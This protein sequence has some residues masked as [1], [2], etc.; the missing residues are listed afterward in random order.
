MF[1]PNWVKLELS[2]KDL[3][4][5]KSRGDDVKRVQEWL[6]FNHIHTDVDGVYGRATQMA[7]KVFQKRTN[8]LNDGIAGPTTFYYLTI[9][10]NKRKLS[11]VFIFT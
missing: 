7:I 4:K 11:I 9:N 8:L 5:Y 10:Y 1:K 3:V 6:N 2:N